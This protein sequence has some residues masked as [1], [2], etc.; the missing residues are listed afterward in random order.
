MQIIYEGNITE[1]SVGVMSANIKSVD[2][3]TANIKNIYKV[4]GRKCQRCC[5]SRQQNQRAPL[6]INLYS[7]IVYDSHTLL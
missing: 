6:H 3:M 2:I 7:F 4:L 1:K 5:F